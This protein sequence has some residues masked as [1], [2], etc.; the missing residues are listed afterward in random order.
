L[1][2]AR[3]V[4]GAKAH[5]ARIV[6]AM[7]AYG[8]THLLTLNGDDFKRFHNSVTVITPADVA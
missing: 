5:D 7:K 3:A 8:I 6:A 1:L 4:K 2:V